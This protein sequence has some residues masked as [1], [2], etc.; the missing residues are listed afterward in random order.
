MTEIELVERLGETIDNMTNHNPEWDKNLSICIT[1][2]IGFARK[3]FP[4]I[5][6]E[7]E[8]GQKIGP[9]ELDFSLT[10]FLFHGKEIEIWESKGINQIVILPTK[11]LKEVKNL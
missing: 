7:Y 8:A 4:D 9:I 11:K 3:A 10:H 5:S 1:G 6:Y 2:P